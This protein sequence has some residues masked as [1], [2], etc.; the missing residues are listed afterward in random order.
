MYSV[1]ERI[2]NRDVIFSDNNYNEIASR[3]IGNTSGVEKITFEFA[4]G[5]LGSTVMVKLR[6]TEKL[7]LAEV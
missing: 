1:S 6:G 7:P 5:T 2:S 4:D 3:Y